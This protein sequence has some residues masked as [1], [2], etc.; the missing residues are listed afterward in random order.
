VVDPG[1]LGLRTGFDEDA[2]AYDRTRP[3]CPPELFDDLV[4]LTGLGPGSRLLEIGCGTGQAT[5][6]LAERG[7][8]V[9]AVEPGTSLG[10]IARRRLAGFPNA[11]VWTGTFEEWRPDGSAFDAVAAFSSLHWVDPEVRYRG[12]AGVLRPGGFLAVGGCHWARPRDAE[13]FWAEVQEDYR[14]VGYAG[15]PPS[16]PEAIGPW[17]LPAEAGSSFEEVAARRYP[18]FRVVYPAGDYLAILATQSG[19]RRL[20]EPLRSEFLER[21]RAR[22]DPWPRVTAT[23]VA[24]LTVGR[25]RSP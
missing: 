25:L 16:P 1:D 24:L 8:A 22:L 18:P 20:G 9:T 14:A 11:R 2:E 10:A 12:P 7:L 21:V 17:H 5:V 19:T 4:A 6:P 23:F 15:E 3:V 13:P